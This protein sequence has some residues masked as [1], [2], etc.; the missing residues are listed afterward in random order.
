[1]NDFNRLCKICEELD[2]VEYGAIIAG[3]ALKIIPALNEI[4]D[5][6]DRT[7]AMLAA[8]MLAS[9][10]A[11]GKL[12]EN[13]YVLMLP[14][15]HAFFGN[16]FDFETAKALVKEFRP[17]G[18]EL[19]EIVDFIVDILGEVSEELKD[20]I[21]TVCLLICAVDGKITRKEKNYI[22]QLIR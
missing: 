16:G 22:K 4:T 5:D 7:N 6:P 11:D 15:L 3:K 10:C 13:E 19:K 14:M 12:D 2:P 8:F 18:K 1:M 9:I 17:E 20:D 21:I